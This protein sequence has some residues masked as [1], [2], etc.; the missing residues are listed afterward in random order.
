MYCMV[1]THT[2]I[3]VF[4]QFNEGKENISKI[5]WYKEWNSLTHI[6]GWLDDGGDLLG[7]EGVLVQPGLSRD[8]TVYA[9]IN[10]LFRSEQ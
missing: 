4:V 5:A 1:H 8:D 6:N 7:G 2:Y 9:F 3:S 10:Q